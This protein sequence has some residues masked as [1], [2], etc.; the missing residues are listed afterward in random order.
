MKTKPYI[1]DYSTRLLVKRR[2]NIRQAIM[3]N[4]ELLIKENQSL[5]EEQLKQ[6]EAP[7]RMELKWDHYHYGRIFTICLNLAHMDRMVRYHPE[8]RASHP[9]QAVGSYARDVSRDIERHVFELLCKE[10]PKG[11]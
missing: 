5:R 9:F 2:K 8:S 11:C 1:K 10:L 7:F 6:K 3:M 4:N